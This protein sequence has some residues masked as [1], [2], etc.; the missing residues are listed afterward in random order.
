MSFWFTHGNDELVTEHSY[1]IGTEESF[2][3]LKR[4]LRK[5]TVEIIQKNE[6]FFRQLS[7]VQ[8]IYSYGFSFSEVDMVY[9]KEICNYLDPASVTWFINSYDSDNNP[10]FRDKIEAYR[11]KVKVAGGG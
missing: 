4:K 9:I 5:D 7:N 11:F 6:K 10:E 2:E 3:K 8:E 1:S